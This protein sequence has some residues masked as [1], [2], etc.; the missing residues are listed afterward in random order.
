MDPMVLTL[1]AED[2]AIL[3]RYTPEAAEIARQNLADEDAWASDSD[4]TLEMNGTNAS[5]FTDV[6]DGEAYGR[7]V[8]DVREKA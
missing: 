8:A 5:R 7:V 2:R 1:T 4:V 6:F 3:A